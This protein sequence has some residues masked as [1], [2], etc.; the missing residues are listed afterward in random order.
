MDENE[1]R[2]G[3][4]AKSSYRVDDGF[5]WCRKCHNYVWAESLPCDEWEETFEIW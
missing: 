5:V 3:N 1:R 2:C 4:C